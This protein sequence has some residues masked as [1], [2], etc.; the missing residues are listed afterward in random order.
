MFATQKNSTRRRSVTSRQ[1]ARRRLAAGLETLEDRRL[2]AVVSHWTGDNTPSDSV[3]SNDATFYN[4]TTYTAG[5]V[6]QAF[7]F[8]GNNDRAI[9]ADD[10]SLALTGS[11]SIEAWVK[12]DGYSPEHGIILFRG[13]DRGGLDPYFL[14]VNSSGQLHFGISG[15]GTDGAGVSTQTPM[16]LG[17]F[18]HVAA[19]LDDATGAM[20][21]YINSLQ[22][23]ATT[24]TVRP[25]ENLDPTQNPGVGIG[26]HGGDPASSPH[27][28][29]FDGVIDEVKLYDSALTPAEVSD[30]FHATKGNLLPSITISDTSVIEG[31]TLL[32]SEGPL[33]GVGEGGLASPRGITFGPGGDL[34]VVSTDTDSVLRYSSTGDFI[35]EF[36]TPG[37][38]GLDYPRDLDFHEGF[39]YVSSTLTDTVLRYD[40]TTGDFDPTF[41]LD[42]AVSGL[43]APRGILFGTDNDLYVASA[44]NDDAILKFDATTGAFAGRVHRQ[45]RRWFGQ[46]DTHGLG[47][48]R[49]LLR[50]Q[51]CREQQFDF[52][53]LSLGGVQ[54][55]VCPVRR[56]RPGWPHRHRVQFRIALRR[57]ARADSVITYD[58]STGEFVGTAVLPGSGGLNTPN[59]LLFDNDGNLLVS[60][61]ASGQIHKYGDAGTAAVN[62]SL[63]YPNDVDVTV[64]YN[65]ADGTA[66][67]GSDYLATS[68]TLTIPAGKTSGTILVEILSDQIGEPEESFAVE[69][70]NPSNAMLGNATGTVTIAEPAFSITDVS[71]VEGEDAPHYKGDF[72]PA[73][74]N[75]LRGVNSMIYGPDGHLYVVLIN[76]NSISKHDGLTGEYIET[77]VEPGSGGLASPRDLV[78]RGDYLYVTSFNTDEV[79]RFHASDGTFDK[80]FVSTGSG[81][82]DNP[83]G[84]TFG[85]DGDLYVAGN[86][87]SN[88]VR[89]D[90][91]S[92]APGRGICRCRKRRAQRAISTDV[93][94]RQPSLRWQFRH[95]RDTSLQWFHRRSDGSIRDRRQWRYRFNTRIDLS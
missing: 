57:C 12:V 60:G 13:D 33:V 82:I 42:S 23:A 25:F 47:P 20:R 87:S 59:S 27:N 46:S 36:V 62:V 24:T 56:S 40:G 67:A 22:V 48:G 31:G 91:T 50:V 73:V 8:D 76:A 1:I 11:L 66:V 90:G 4:G 86:G 41:V 61:R 28:F 80:V 71:V 65:T 5:Q 18:V 43:E 14:T 39:L 64:P 7:R 49:K 37:D 2:L 72:I 74:G 26:N 63:S 44:G 75:D 83:D 17:E 52:T 3:G 81:G 9:I 15:G 6:G 94:P 16:P 10:P 51:H 69:L 58:A 29:P 53:L 77:F 89:Y 35:G 68:G 45:R 54:R 84:L 88:V 92:G 55:H 79:L 19:T 85:P 34:F 78:F 32:S 95:G 70:G 30:N 21:L 38:G 93:W